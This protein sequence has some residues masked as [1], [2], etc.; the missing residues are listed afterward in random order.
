[1]SYRP[2]WNLPSGF[3]KPRFPLLLVLF[4]AKIGKNSKRF[5]FK[6]CHTYHTTCDTVNIFHLLMEQIRLTGILLIA[7]WTVLAKYWK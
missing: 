3:S 6:G 2:K 4:M 1:M 5:A 7:V